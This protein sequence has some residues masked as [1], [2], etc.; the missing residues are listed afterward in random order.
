MILL[1]LPRDVGIDKD[2][3]QKSKI[4]NQTDSL[5]NYILN[6]LDNVSHIILILL[7]VIFVVCAFLFYKS[8]LKKKANSEDENSDINE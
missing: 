2:N 5:I 8:R 6:I 3:F 1:A 4:Y 7:I